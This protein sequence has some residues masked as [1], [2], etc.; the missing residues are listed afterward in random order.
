MLAPREADYR[1]APGAVERFFAALIDLRCA[2]LNPEFRV[3]THVEKADW[4]GQRLIGGEPATGEIVLRRWW[5]DI[6]SVAE[7]PDR[8]RG[9]DEYDVIASG[10][11]PPELALLSFDPQFD[12]AR[13]EFEIACCLRPQ[14]VSLSDFHNRERFLFRDVWYWRWWFPPPPRGAPHRAKDRTGLFT[15][16]TT[17]ETMEV[18]EAGSA[19][20]WVEFRFQKWVFPR[21]RHTL[22]LLPASVVSAAE[23]AFQVSF[24]QGCAW[25]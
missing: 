12:A 16:P 24:A 17:G 8:L 23:Q 1:A 10:A 6:N 22:D 4:V 25:G 7:I 20:F 13:Y 15:N 11:G 9:L 5:S 21:I 18:P 3:R 2:P 19:S 14:V